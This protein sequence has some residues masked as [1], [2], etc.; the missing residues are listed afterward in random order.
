MSHNDN[1][2]LAATGVMSF[3]GVPWLLLVIPSVV[4]GLAGDLT[5][6]YALMEQGLH[7]GGF[8]IGALITLILI[9]GAILE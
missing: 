3:L 8:I 4:Q 5:A 6:S 7:W 9:V 1:A 2:T